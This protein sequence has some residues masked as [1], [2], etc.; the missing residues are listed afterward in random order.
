M[1]T[2]QNGTW[3]EYAPPPQSL[4]LRF[5][6][7]S[8]FGRGA[9]RTRILERWREK[10]GTIVDITREGIH[11]RLDISDNVT[12]GKILASSVVYDKKE[13]SYL[14]NACKEGG[15]FVDVG[16]NIGYY[17]LVLAHSCNCKVVAIEPNPPTLKR[18][19]FNIAINRH[20][21]EKISIIPLGVGPEGEFE[22]Y[23]DNN[24]GAASLH[25]TIVPGSNNV[26]K[27]NTKPLLDILEDQQVTKI[28]ALKIDIE[29]MEDQALGPFISRADAGMLPKCIII[30]DDQK[31]LWK[32]DLMQQLFDKGYVEKARTRGNAILQLSTH[33]EE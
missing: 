16:A 7:A 30:E 26:V 13:L 11:Y 18:L 23:S 9:I 8:G 15:V 6:I 17:S 12:D 27:I 28:D 31:H 20:L 10:Y 1:T 3:G 25:A 22:L 33:L 2:H 19:E 5:L 29:G 4:F 32:T 24:L 21:R 14:Q